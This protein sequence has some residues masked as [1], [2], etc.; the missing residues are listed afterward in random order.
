MGLF[1]LMLLSL[2]GFALSAN[3]GLDEDNFG[4]VAAVISF[5]SL[6][7]MFF[8]PGIIL[9]YHGIS[10]AM[11]ERSGAFKA[12]VG[13]AVVAVFAGIVGIGQLNMRME[14]PIAAPM[15]ILHTLAAVLPGIA[16]IG[17][18]ARGSWWRG[19]AV[20]GVTWRQVTLA[21]GL[22]IAIGAMSALFVNSIGGLLATIVV[23]TRDGVFHDVTTFSGDQFY[24]PGVWDIIGDAQFYLTRNE[25]WVVNILAVALIPPF[26]EEA[27]KGVN[28]R[29]LMRR[30]TTRAQAF[31]L[32]AAAGAGFGFVEALLYGAG[33]TSA[34][35]GDWWRIMLLRGG[36]SSL[37]C[38]ATGLVGL[39]WWYW[40]IG[41]HKRRAA[42]LYLTAVCLHAFWNGFSVTLDS[43]IFWV[44]TLDD[45]TLE[46]VAYGFVI[47][48]G[49]IFVSAIP[50]IARRLREAAPPSVVGTPFGAMEPWLG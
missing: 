36:S 15:P 20:G 33:V 1:G 40:S 43:E 25:Q 44:G 30:N 32:G 48:F 38:L 24:D 39:G 17:F 34:S 11:G 21:W 23:L 6:G 14:S 37:H 16:Y 50:L 42:G 31:L 3:D 22:A 26:V 28:V 46:R 10:S 12:P 19:K 45:K 18:A 7:M 47:V 9:T 35:L 4:V 13:L 49:A 29:L 27:L 5:T 8:V 41:G 2:L